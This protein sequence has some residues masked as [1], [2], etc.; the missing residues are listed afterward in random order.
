[1]EV[2]TGQNVVGGAG[3]ARGLG[4]AGPVETNAEVHGGS[5]N[6]FQPWEFFSRQFWPS[7]G[8]ALVVL[9]ADC[10]DPL[11]ESKKRPVANIPRLMTELDQHAAQFGPY[12]PY[13]IAVAHRLAVAFWCAGE[14]DRAIG[15]LDQALKGLA[16]WAEPHHPVRLDVMGTLAEI[17]IERGRLEPAAT[18][19]REIL[20]LCIWH[21]GK[22]HPSTLAAKG[23]LALVLFELGQRE[24]ASQ[25]DDQAYEDANDVLG[26][27]HP[28]TCVLAWNRALRYEANGDASAARSIIVD[29]LAWLITQ[30]DDS[31]ATD[32][33]MIRA[34]LAKRLNLD[35]VRAC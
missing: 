33:R 26:T 19:Y 11:S 8:A 7:M 20:G 30:T 17:L 24:E 12:H 2:L 28:V 1:M 29:E 31:L 21:F 15:I 3:A 14:F 10:T 22:L 23:D 34:M 35:S 16:S 4:A 18:I 5:F 13:T 6:P 9:I 25:L 27:N 32:Q